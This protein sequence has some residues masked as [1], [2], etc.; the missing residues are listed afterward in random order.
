MSLKWWALVQ[1]LCSWV[2]FIRALV[3][4][5]EGQKVPVSDRC[6]R[7][8][9]QFHKFHT[10]ILILPL[11]ALLSIAFR[12]ASMV[13]RWP[14]A[15]FFCFMCSRAPRQVLESWRNGLRVY[16]CFTLWWLLLQPI[17]VC[18]T[19]LFCCGNG[20]ITLL[21][22][23]DTVHPCNAISFMNVTVFCG[24]VLLCGCDFTYYILILFISILRLLYCLLSDSGFLFYVY[25]IPFYS[26]IS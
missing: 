17:V 16:V 8:T 24:V 25:F 13:Q 7:V 5:G 19:L 2:H 18:P 23:S 4:G 9:V 22:G 26:T 10:P 6:K 11:H 3:E 21:K 15:I 14:F 20:R 12:S 1:V